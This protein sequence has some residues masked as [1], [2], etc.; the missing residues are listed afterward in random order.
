MRSTGY[1][2]WLESPPA[3]WPGEEANVTYSEV[4]LERAPAFSR[5]ANEMARTRPTALLENKRLARRGADVFGAGFIL[6]N[7]DRNSWA[8]NSPE[9]LRVTQPYLTGEDFNNSPILEPSRFIINFGEMSEE[10]AARFPEAFERVRRL[11]RPARAS[12]KQRDR[13]E[14]WWLYATRA[15]EVTRYLQAHTRCLCIARMSKHIAFGFV[16]PGFVLADTVILVLSDKASCLSCLQSRVHSEW[17]YRLAGAFGTTL[18]YTS[19]DCLETFPFPQSWETNSRLEEIGEAYNGARA[20]LMA[21]NG[22]GLTKTYNR[23]HDPDE[24]SSEV[25]RLRELHDA[26]DQAVLDAYG[27]A[28]LRPTCEFLHDHD[29]KNDDD[30]SGRTRLRKKPWRYRWPDNIRDEVLARLLELNRSRN[31]AQQRVDGADGV[32]HAGILNGAGS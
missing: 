24:L 11:V 32:G 10:E 20:A 30:D 27:W 13:R 16:R 9:N 5:S 8:G 14:L 15:P 22:E 31:A 25:L 29:D 2:L 3:Q 26:M 6:S 28:D 1:G 4:G 7:E 21:R 17:V 18:R 19:S 23:F 12:I